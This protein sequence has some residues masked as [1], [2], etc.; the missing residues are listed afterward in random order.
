[1]DEYITMAFVCWLIYK[2]SHLL[3]DLKKERE[4]LRKYA[5]ARLTKMVEDYVKGLPTKERTN[6]QAGIIEGRLSWNDLALI[7][8]IEMEEKGQDIEEYLMYV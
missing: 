1:M 8:L 2:L 7:V 6:I 5:Y 3:F 4:A